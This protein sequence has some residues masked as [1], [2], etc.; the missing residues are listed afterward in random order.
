M[1]KK[2][3]KPAKRRS[4]PARRAVKATARK[5]RKAGPS[6]ARKSKPSPKPKPKPKPRPQRKPK[7]AGLL[8]RIGF[9]VAATQDDWAGYKRAF[10]RQLRDSGWTIGRPGT[11]RVDIDY[12]PE[13]G[14]AGDPGALSQW[15]NQF[16][17][18]NVHAIVTAGTEASLICK[19]ATLASRT[20][21]VFASAGDPV[22]SG[23]VASLRQPGGN[24]TGCSNL[25]AT[26]AVISSG[27]ELMV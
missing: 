15:A 7:P 24:L 22:G 5:A 16:V 17:S 8:Q 12:Q 21:V 9:L 25:Q 1:A 4:K 18:N 14:A 10:E 13:A 2:S 23:L 27:I 26:R 6:R 11:D 20:P 19:N 3:K